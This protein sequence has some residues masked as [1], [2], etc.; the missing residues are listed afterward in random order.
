M[1][2]KLNDAAQVIGRSGGGDLCRS[3]IDDVKFSAG[4]PAAPRS[5]SSPRFSG[6]AA[7]CGRYAE[8]SRYRRLRSAE[9][10]RAFVRAII[11]AT[12]GPG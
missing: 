9:E 5:R 6:L 11:E 8:H 3:L 12:N 7:D 10:F 4:T 1:E 2:Y